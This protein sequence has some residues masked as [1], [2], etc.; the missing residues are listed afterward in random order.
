MCCTI[1]AS[2]T[3]IDELITGLPLKI[4]GNT[5]PLKSGTNL[6]HFIS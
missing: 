6:F 2:A 5:A 1:S 3:V 4:P